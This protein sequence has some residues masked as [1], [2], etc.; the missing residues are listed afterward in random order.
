MCQCSVRSCF[1]Y[2]HFPHDI[3]FRIYGYLTQGLL[4]SM[5]GIP[6]YR[7]SRVSTELQPYVWY[8]GSVRAH[9]CEFTLSNEQQVLDGEVLYMHYYTLVCPEY[10]GYSYSRKA[11]S[12]YCSLSVYQMCGA[13]T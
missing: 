2:T 9:A 12:L 11:V 7:E 3:I 6:R 13:R 8:A 5:R 1:S 10:N 4:Y